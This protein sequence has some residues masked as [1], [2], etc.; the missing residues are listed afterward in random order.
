MKG[1]GVKLFT[2]GEGLFYVQ[3][4]EDAY[5]GHKRAIRSAG[6]TALPN[7]ITFG[8]DLIKKYSGKGITKKGFRS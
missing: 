4:I 1:F 7:L 3:K 6:I 2:P 8:N 5:F